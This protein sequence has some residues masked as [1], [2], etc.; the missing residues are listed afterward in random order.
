MG[1]PRPYRHTIEWV[2]MHEYSVWEDKRWY[3]A[4]S[5]AYDWCT[6]QLSS[7]YYD[8]LVRT[9]RAGFVPIIRW[10]WSALRNRGPSSELSANFLVRSSY[11]IL[12]PE[13]S[14]WYRR[15]EHDNPLC[16]RAYY[17]RICL[18]YASTR[19]RETEKRDMSHTTAVSSEWELQQYQ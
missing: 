1:L 3:F 7:R 16:T 17:W 18:V 13:K 4:T 5:T 19:I 2:Q 14:A 6:Y 9:F 12:S 10:S 15:C 8:L 11:H